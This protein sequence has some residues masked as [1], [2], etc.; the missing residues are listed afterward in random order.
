MTGV[1]K[2]VKTSVP[3]IHPEFAQC[4]K[5]HGLVSCSYVAVLFCYAH[6][7]IEK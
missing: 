6:H 2:N 4:C 3:E 1:I 5:G 7:R